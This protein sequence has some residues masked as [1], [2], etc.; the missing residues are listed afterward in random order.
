MGRGETSQGGGRIITMIRR[1]GG[2]D[3]PDKDLGASP[4]NSLNLI[5]FVEGERVTNR[6]DF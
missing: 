3:P 2:A 6:L 5:A 4:L 1:F